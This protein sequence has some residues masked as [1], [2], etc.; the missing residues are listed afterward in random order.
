LGLFD[1]QVFLA[2]LIYSPTKKT[3]VITPIITTTMFVPPITAL[4]AANVLCIQI[5]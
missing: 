5:P 2:K 1:Q 3:I 4:L